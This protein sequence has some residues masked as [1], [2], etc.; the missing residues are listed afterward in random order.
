MV[1]SITLHQIYRLFN[2]K[3]GGRIITNYELEWAGEKIIMA[4]IRIHATQGALAKNHTGTLES[5]THFGL[6]CL[7]V[8]A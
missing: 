2:I 1:D 4:Y 5:V 3:W 8:Y 6:T 7:M